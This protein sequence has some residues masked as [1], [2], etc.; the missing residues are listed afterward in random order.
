MS[1]TAHDHHHDDENHERTNVV[2]LPVRRA[3]T[4][5]DT[6]GLEPGGAVVGELLTER[7]SAELDRRMAAQRA[8]DAVGAVVRVVRHERTRTVGR[9]VLRNAGYAVA[10][11]RIRRQERRARRLH[12]DLEQAITTL[13]VNAKSAEDFRVLRELEEALERRRTGAAQRGR[14]RRIEILR[15]SGGVVVLLAG[16]HV[17]FLGFAA[18]QA[19]VGA[20]SL[21][22]RWNDVVGFWTTVAELSPAGGY[23]WAWAIVGAGTWAARTIPVGRSR[24]TLPLWAGDDQAVPADGR[25]VVV[26]EAAVLSA[27]RHLGGLP[28]LKQA[29][30]QGWGSSITPT[31]VQVPHRDGNGVRMQLVLPQGVPVEEIVKRKTVLAHNLVRLPVE[32]WPSEPKDRAGVLDLWVADPGAL[33]GPVDPW[34]L[35][36]TDGPTDYFTAVP[37]GVNIRGEVVR[38][39]LFE[40]NYA[41]S[42]VMGSGKSSLFITLVAGAVLDPLVEV[43]VF[44][45][46]ENFDYEPLKPRLRT[47]RTGADA[48][49]VKACLATLRE[50]YAE[51]DV[52]GKALREHQE[53]KVNRTVAAKD[54]RL[55]PRVVVIDECQ[56]LFMHEEHGEEAADVVTKLISAARKYA[57]TLLFA[58]PEASTASLP[59]KVTAVTS[60]KA[61]FAIGDQQSNDAI[62]G[63]GSYK[64]GISAVSLEP[65]TDDGPGDIGTAMVRGIMAKPG[66]LRSFYL[67]PAELTEITHRAMDLRNGHVPTPTGDDVDEVDFLTDLAHVLTGHKHLRTAE[68]LNALAALRPDHYGKYTSRTLADQLREVRVPIVKRDSGQSAVDVNDVAEAVT[69]RD[70]E[71]DAGDDDE[72]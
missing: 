2:R 39:Q 30:K 6:D 50:L 25:N 27:L 60:C 35:L 72:S 17:L 66:L 13:R 22:D 67:T 43:D 32:V 26:D 8:R 44:V 18:A 19:V 49:T 12:L 45:L 4:T 40:K 7:E 10:G 24:G 28:L 5:P 46:A 33:S 3:D 57:V 11:A 68:V 16:G 63:T 23:W 65:A 15:W 29:F 42:G 41:A 14:E 51:L 58:T 1:T 31:W 47:L 21:T 9:A 55:R 69:M 59:R 20:G 52:R 61:C 36:D 34:P 53:R 71:N 70:M 38:A 37:V 48:D 54:A 62:L 64:A 56:A